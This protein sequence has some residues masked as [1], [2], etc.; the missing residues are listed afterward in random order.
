MVYKASSRIARAVAQRN[1]IPEKGGERGN[2]K[3]VR[4]GEKR[5]RDCLYDL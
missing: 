1:P 4:D 2:G 3:G 5:E